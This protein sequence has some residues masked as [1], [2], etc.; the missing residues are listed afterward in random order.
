MKTRP[1]E[2]MKQ[3]ASAP[4]RSWRAFTLIELLTVIAIIGILAGMIMGAVVSA[5][6]K[7]KVAVAKLQMKN[8]L[9]SINQYETTYGR[10]PA[11]TLTSPHS[12]N[13]IHDISF[14]FNPPN[15]IIPLAS[16]PW[17]TNVITTNT[18]IIAILMDINVGAN[19]NHQK[20]PRQMVFNEEKLVNQ[21]GVSGV[22]AFDFQYRDPWGNTY[23]ITLDLNRDGKCSDAFYRQ[24]SVSQ[25]DVGNRTGLNGLFN[26]IDDNGNGDTFEYN[27]SAM[28]W[29]MGPDGLLTVGGAVP[30]ANKEFNKDNVLGWQ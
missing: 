26:N 18:D 2:P 19:I 3:P 20:N 1:F 17:R 8:L 22:S 11:P 10:L 27:G 24:Q 9:A 6:G 14:G 4:R 25:V 16:N 12:D 23:I 30:R 15:N 13:G 29:S 28:I 21:E 5:K 7:A